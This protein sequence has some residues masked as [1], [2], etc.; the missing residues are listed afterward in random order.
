M[1]GEIRNFFHWRKKTQNNVNKDEDKDI[2]TKL[3]FT[4]WYIYIALVDQRERQ[5]LVEDNHHC[6]V[7]NGIVRRLV[8]T[9]YFK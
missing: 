5:L 2:Q 8:I 9:Y 4:I 3:G 1:V 6:C 7:K